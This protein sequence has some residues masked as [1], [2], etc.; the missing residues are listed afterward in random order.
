MDRAAME[1]LCKGGALIRQH[2]RG[3]LDV[4]MRVFNL[5]PW[6]CSSCDRKAYR[7]ARH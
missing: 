4:F 2:R 5:F 1:C 3:W 6:R 7:F